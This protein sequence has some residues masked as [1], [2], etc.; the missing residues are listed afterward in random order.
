MTGL[1]SSSGIRRLQSNGVDELARLFVN[2]RD[3]LRAMVNCRIRGRLAARFDASDVIQESY[4]RAKQ[5]LQA[6]LDSPT[7]PPVVWL[8]IVCKQIL[9]ESIRKNLRMSRSPEFEVYN[10]GDQLIVERIADSLHSVTDA[11]AR[12]ELLGIVSEILATLDRTDREIIEMRHNEGLTFPEIAELIDLKME[13]AKKR[14]YRAI[15]KFR[16]C[17]EQE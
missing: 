12:K 5:R 14:Y 6:Y 7:I 16:E 8:R 15:D 11:M 10:T 13:T 1:Q 2:N 3:A 9:T 4:I 17:L